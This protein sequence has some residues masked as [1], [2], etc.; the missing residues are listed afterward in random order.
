VRQATVRNNVPST[1]GAH[2]HPVAATRHHPQ[3]GYE[4]VPQRSSAQRHHGTFNEGAAHNAFTIASI[5]EETLRG[6][7]TDT[8]KLT[9]CLSEFE[10]VFTVNAPQEPQCPKKADKQRK[11]RFVKEMEQWKLLK[12]NIVDSQKHAENAL[13]S[14][15]SSTDAVSTP[16]VRTV[17]SLFSRS[18]VGEESGAAVR[19]TAALIKAFNVRRTLKPSQGVLGKLD[20]ALQNLLSVIQR[21]HTK[22]QQKDVFLAV[23]IL[24]RLDVESVRSVSCANDFH[25]GGCPCHLRKTVDAASEPWFS[26]YR[27]LVK[28]AE[29]FVQQDHSFVRG[30]GRLKFHVNECLHNSCSSFQRFAAAIPQPRS[31]LCA[32]GE[33]NL[34]AIEFGFHGT[35]EAVIDAILCRGFDVGRRSGQAYGRGE[36][37]GLSPETSEGYAKGGESMLVCAM[38]KQ[39]VHRGTPT[40]AVVD[41]PLDDRGKAY[42]LPVGVMSWSI[43]DRKQRCQY[44]A[45]RSA[46]TTMCSSL[47]DMLD[48]LLRSSTVP[49]SEVPKHLLKL[50]HLLPSLNASPLVVLILSDSAPTVARL[51]FSGTWV[52]CGSD[53]SHLFPEDPLRDNNKC[54]SCASA[55]PPPPKR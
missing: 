7:V 14:L 36:Y 13:M 55:G 51:S 43:G 40:I 28:V 34:D 8:S 1:V 52:S 4:S 3:E 5:V 23:W 10:R 54:P 9:D 50:A 30:K 39:H 32:S 15:F 25:D 11:Q 27:A 2:H 41:N 49:N 37:F 17:L 12:Q 6:I 44:P 29:V 22:L 26:L 24:M 42:V 45:A 19:V 35:S 48:Y 18:L 38:L 31:L 33:L 47:D 16:L 21:D 53:S 46:W 20:N